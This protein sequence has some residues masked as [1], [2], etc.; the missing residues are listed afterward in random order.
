MGILESITQQHSSNVLPIFLPFVLPSSMSLPTPSPAVQERLLRL[1]EAQEAEKRLRETEAASKRLAEIAKEEAF[2]QELE[3]NKVDWEAEILLK[4]ESVSHEELRAACDSLVPRYSDRDAATCLQLVNLVDVWRGC[5]PNQYRCSGICVI[6]EEMRR[7]LTMDLYQT[8]I[9]TPPSVKYGKDKVVHSHKAPS[10]MDRERALF[11]FGYMYHVF[12]TFCAEIDTDKA[13]VAEEKK[14]AFEEKKR[15]EEKKRVEELKAK[16][17]QFVADTLKRL[18][19]HK[20]NFTGMDAMKDGLNPEYIWCI[21]HATGP[22]YMYSKY[23]SSSVTTP[24]DWNHHYERGIL[25]FLPQCPVCSKQTSLQFEGDG[26]GRYKNQIGRVS[27]SAGDHYHWDAATGKHSKLMATH[28]KLVTTEKGTGYNAH[29]TFSITPRHEVSH[30]WNRDWNPK[31]PEGILAA[32]LLKEKQI[33][34]A[35]AEVAKAMKRLADL[36]G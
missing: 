9:D 26:C 18:G 4:M 32:K 12:Q 17:E 33:A 27:C 5:F 20:H 23:H 6:L 1:R 21:G 36:R 35:E 15:A 8:I 11:I 22:V 28:T 16:Q 30:E 25:P 13:R 7:G 29:V 3:A 10:R 14:R 2:Q 19:T 24:I 31:D 34:E